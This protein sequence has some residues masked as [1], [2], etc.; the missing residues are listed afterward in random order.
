MKITDAEHR[1]LV[2][3]VYAY[4]Y[5]TDIFHYIK[6]EYAI[7]KLN[8][9]SVSFWHDFWSALPDKPAI[10]RAPFYRICDIA[11]RIYDEN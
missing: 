7:K 8:F 9:C 5:Y 2:A 1:E 4:D 10:H 3:Q 11:E 6:E